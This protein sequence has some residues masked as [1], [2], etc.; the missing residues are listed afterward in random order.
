MRR[1]PARA[2][3]SPAPRPRLRRPDATAAAA[4]PKVPS[5]GCCRWPQGWRAGCAAAAPPAESESAPRS[6][7]PPDCRPAPHHVQH[8]PRRYRVAGKKILADADAQRR[9]TRQRLRVDVGAALDRLEDFLISLALPASTSRSSP[10]SL[11]ATSERTPE[12]IS[13]T[14]CSMGWVKLSR[15]PGSP[16]NFSWISLTSSA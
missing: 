7:R 4:R 10:N 12:I 5:P 9:L 13:L 1:C 8:G 11:T 16:S 14:R 3:P 2:A 6:P 15:W